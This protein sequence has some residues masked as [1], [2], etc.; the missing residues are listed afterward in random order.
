MRVQDGSGAT[1]SHGVPTQVEPV[2]DDMPLDVGSVEVDGANPQLDYDARGLHHELVVRFASPSMPGFS[3]PS[4]AVPALGF[5]G[6]VGLGVAGLRLVG[7]PGFLS[8]LV[9]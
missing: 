4:D 2:S 7:S 9:N 1:L 8:P 3:A 6:A 5:L